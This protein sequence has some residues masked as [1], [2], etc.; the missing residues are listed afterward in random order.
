[1]IYCIQY[2]LLA[3]SS[4]ACLFQKIFQHLEPIKI[5][6]HVVMQHNEVL[7]Q[8]PDELHSLVLM[9]FIKQQIDLL[10]PA[11]NHSMF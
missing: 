3:Q 6:Q 2:A 1:M 8:A 7:M 5:L 11:R 4:E 9:S 10:A